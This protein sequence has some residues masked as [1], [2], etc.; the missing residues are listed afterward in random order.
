MF[1]ISGR[2]C[3]VPSYRELKIY[4]FWHDHVFSEGVI[5]IYIKDGW[6]VM[7]GSI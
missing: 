5:P 4:P 7:V 3:I 1:W 6:E 2:G